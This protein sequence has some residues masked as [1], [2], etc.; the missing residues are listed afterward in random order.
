[1]YWLIKEI[2][3][4]NNLQRLWIPRTLDGL[5]G[6]GCGLRPARAL[7]GLIHVTPGTGGVWGTMN[8]DQGETDV[9]AMQIGPLIGWLLLG[10]GVKSS[11]TTTTVVR[12]LYSRNRISSSL[13]CH[14]L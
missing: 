12:E 14:S 9:V 8:H 6:H 10:A 5:V 13:L 3:L 4:A 11:R 2:R 7:T 1:M